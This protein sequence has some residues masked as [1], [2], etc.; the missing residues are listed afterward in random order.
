MANKSAM[1]VPQKL[2]IA[3]PRRF[4]SGPNNGPP[5]PD[6]DSAGDCPVFHN[7]VVSKLTA[8]IYTPFH[9]IKHEIGAVFE[10][11]LETLNTWV[12]IV[13]ESQYTRLSNRDGSTPDAETCTL[14]LAIYLVTRQPDDGVGLDEL[15]TS[16]KRFHSNLYT[17]STQ[18]VPIIQAGMLLAIYEQGQALHQLSYLTI[19]ACVR[20]AQAVGMH[21]TLEK[22]I[23]LASPSGGEM[24]EQRHIWWC[25]VILER[26][27][28]SFPT[29]L[30]ILLT[31]KQ[32]PILNL[33][34]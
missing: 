13:A 30:L 12:P 18:S 33:H 8:P 14:L 6:S 31:T 32:N 4:F 15:Y 22:D 29:Q 26:S 17:I 9:A 23:E 7:N 27:V 28:P 5:S 11:Y 10:L 25:L 19:G 1:A 21:R 20:L 2:D 34:Y 3:A 24:Q 16:L